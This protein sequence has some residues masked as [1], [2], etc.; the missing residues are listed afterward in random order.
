MLQ[1]PE[2]GGVA[3]G[4][5]ATSAD[6]GNKD[7]Y[8]EK[9]KEKGGDPAAPTPAPAPS[10]FPAPKP[11]AAVEV[12][13]SCVKCGGIGYTCRRIQLAKRLGILVRNSFKLPHSVVK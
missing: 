8:K 1:N 10:P 12:P 6:G 3:A 5:G 4:N 11:P 13:V 7:R 2:A 9:E